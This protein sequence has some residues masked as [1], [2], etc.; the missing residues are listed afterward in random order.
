MTVLHTRWMLLF[1]A[2]SLLAACSPYAF[3]P[4]DMDPHMVEHCP[5]LHNVGAVTRETWYCFT[6]ATTPRVLDGPF[7]VEMDGA[8]TTGTMRAD[9]LVAWQTTDSGG[10]VIDVHEETPGKKARQSC[11]PW[12]VKLRMSSRQP[13]LAACAR[14]ALRRDPDLAGSV[15]INLTVAPNGGV[16]D[17]RVADNTLKDEEL[18]RCVLRVYTA[19]RF[20]PTGDGETCTTSVPLTLAVE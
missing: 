19:V 4:A 10:K 18:R 5:A 13:Q 1:G 6:P 3:W 11:V 15:V 20:A 16:Y 7:S 17:A 8:L 14:E 2:L 12:E 9:E